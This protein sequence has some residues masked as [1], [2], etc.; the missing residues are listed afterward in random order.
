MFTGD[1]LPRVK[2]FRI[3]GA[4]TMIAN[5]VSG[6]ATTGGHHVIICTTIAGAVGSRGKDFR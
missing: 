3:R 4:A 5:F 2:P 1:S 6:N